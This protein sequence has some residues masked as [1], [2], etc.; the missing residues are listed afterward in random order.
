MKNFF[1]SSTPNDSESSQRPESVH[2]AACKSHKSSSLQQLLFSILFLLPLFLLSLGQHFSALF[3]ADS[4]PSILNPSGYPL[5]L[6]FLELALL[7]LLLFVNSSVFSNGLRS[8][9]T[10][11]LETFAAISSLSAI[12]LSLFAIMQLSLGDSAYS[13][14]LC[15]DIAGL[16]LTLAAAG[17]YLAERTET[18]LLLRL[19]KLSS[20][21]PDKARLE[22]STGLHELPAKELKPGD[23]VI[24][25]QG[26]RL[27][28]DGRIVEGTAVL[29]EARI[30]GNKEPS[31]CLIGDEVLGG[32]ACQQGSFKYCVTRTQEA[33]SFMHTLQTSLASFQAQGSENLLIPAAR[34]FFLIL[35]IISIAAGIFWFSA[36]AAWPVSFSAFFST[37]LLFPSA[38]LLLAP[39]CWQFAAEKALSQGILLQK[40]AA[41]EAACQI[42]AVVLDKT[43]NLTKGQPVL[44]DIIP[45]GLSQGTLLAL[46]ASA[47]RESH[48]PLARTILQAAEYRRL[49]IQRVAAFN[50]AAGAG[51][52]AL[53]NGQALRVGQQAWLQEQDVIISA[54]LL[55][56]ADQL[57]TKG[58]TVLFVSTGRT[59]KGLLVLDDPL[60][61]ES[62]EAVMRLQAESVQVILLSSAS[63][64]TTQSIARQAGI[65]TIR[66]EI[67]PSDKLRELQLLQSHGQITAMI[68]EGWFDQKALLCADFAISTGKG[69]SASIR[70]ADAILLHQDLR[71]VSCLLEL[72]RFTMKKLNTA[73][74]LAFGCSLLCL[75]ASTGLLHAFGG[76]SFNALWPLAACLLSL[77]LLLLRIRQL[78]RFQ[79]SA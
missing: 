67:A 36:D 5:H 76:P 49:R 78:R 53:L 26:E 42:T 15:F 9:K 30:T 14:L 45:E 77:L 17:R 52:E 55:T 41:L 20:L 16:P 10:P 68:G 22:D 73:A 2:A 29:D 13:Q 35:L 51:A 40:S 18:A 61:P 56:R 69:T 48:H 38:L 31:S 37:L 33:S 64:R 27:P 7:L 32:S 43:G 54:N 60:R 23:I 58:K 59:C 75:P 1:R 4:W 25:Q 11:S 34:S 8:L 39:P 74:R 71:D 79:F 57:A 63:K 47:E 19:K 28:A 65:K 12:I 70:N 3:S 24:I 44:T 50:E 46:A 72:S 6:A 66:A 62:R 21:F